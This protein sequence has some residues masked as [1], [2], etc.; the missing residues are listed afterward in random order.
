M[1]R[2][3]QRLIGAALTACLAISALAG[4]PTEDAAKALRDG[5]ARFVA[6][7]PTHPHTDMDRVA[8]TG[9]N[10]QKPM[11][12]ILGCSDSRV[13][14]ERIF[15]LGVGDAFVVR[16]AGNVSDTDEIGSAEYGT[17]HLNTPLMVVLGHTKCGAVTAVATGAQVHGSIPGLVD[18]IIPAVESAKKKHPGVTGK[19]LVSF[20]IEENVFQSMSDVLTRSEEIRGLVKQDKL[21]IIGAV[22]DIDTG[23]VAWVG[24]HPEQSA[25]LEAPPAPAAARGNAQAA[26]PAGEHGKAKA[27]SGAAADASKVVSTGSFEAP[28]L[29]V[30]KREAY[31]AKAGKAADFAELPEVVPENLL[32]FNI[33]AGATALTLLVTIGAAFSLS[34]VTKADGSSGRA[35]TVGTKL[36]GGFGLAVTGVLFLATIADRASHTIHAAM[37]NAE[38]FSDQNTMVGALEG[39]TLSVRLAVKNFLINN[40]D[41]DLAQFSDA[42]ASLARK[43][44]VADKSLKNPE[45]AKMLQEIMADVEKYKEAFSKVVALVDERNGVVDT[46]LGVAAS[47]ATTLLDEVANTAAADGDPEVAF[48]AALTN[49][50]L[51]SGRLAFF[52]YLRSHDEKFA[53]ESRK[54]AEE[55]KGELGVLESKVQNPN[56]K[57]WFREAS[58][59]LDFWTVNLERA[60]QL[61]K[62]RDELVNNGLDK[63]GPQIVE[64]SN[65][66][67]ASLK[68][69]KDEVAAEGEKASASASMTGG[70][71]AFTTA[72]FS[73]LMSFFIIRGITGPLGRVVST[74]KTVASGDLT[75]APLGITSR[76]EIGI[77]SQA[78]DAMSNSL[79]KMVSDIKGTS[80]QVAAAATQVAASAEELAQTVR[81]QEEAATQVASAVTELSASVAEVATKSSESATNAQESMKQAASGGDLVQQTV[82]QL[83]QIND[84]FGEVADVVGTLEKQG[85]EV[86]RV[87]QVIQE[88][89]DQTNLLALNA[90]IEAARAGEHGRGFAV[91]AD[92]VRKLAERTTQAT[93][94]VAKTIGGMQTG[95]TKAGEAMKTGRQTVDDGAKMGTQAGDAVGVIVQAQKS[96]EQMAISI[97]AATKEQAAATEEI[98]RTIERMSA[99]NSQSSSAASQASQ[100]AN[101]LSQQ[102][103]TLNGYMGRYKV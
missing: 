45:R 75:L 67:A 51:Q 77:L 29:N 71:V 78:T 35:L 63:I 90:A 65:R 6:G 38:H 42:T 43:I 10:G 20:A 28:A 30:V 39:D 58:G 97:A 98:S 48:D 49:S 12:T 73:G 80:T 61:Q 21:Q 57:K 66:I 24:E 3:T 86:G 93:G 56:R 103:E 94:E 62:Q 88:I 37:A 83:S 26:A 34:R 50:K 23:K 53:V 69:T 84:R 74:L 91:V 32:L 100:A 59:A 27:V 17:G 76:D 8:D 4:T 96:A 79:K 95:T 99:A 52:R 33:F 89:A 36:A 70:I 54:H 5:N 15:D 22:Y 25:L 85:Q 64:T 40:S 7:K 102:A 41:E 101:N 46:Q 92:E 1:L 81:S 60:Q 72:I 13:A 11:V 87:V 2:K 68:T 14:L 18:N 44:D 55:V 19:D 31:G 47:R 16:V 9:A 82:T